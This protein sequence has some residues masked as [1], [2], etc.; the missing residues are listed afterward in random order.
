MSM[1]CSLPVKNKDELSKLKKNLSQTFDM[2]I[3]GNA[4]HILGMHIT[5]DRSNEFIYLCSKILKGFNMES[6][7]L[8]NTVLF[9]H[10][11]D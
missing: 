2:K 11:K 6:A 9:M 4:K 5:Q 3:L 1:T 10:G 7:K 8:L